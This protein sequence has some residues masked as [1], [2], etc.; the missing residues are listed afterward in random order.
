MKVKAVI[1]Y[2]QPTLSV[3]IKPEAAN[4]ATSQHRGDPEEEKEEKLATR[5]RVFDAFH[6]NRVENVLR[7]WLK[8][9]CGSG[10]KVQKK[11]PETMM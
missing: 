3:I 6:H 10:V 2:P 1:H 11:T 4:W 5:T 9:T 7:A 8:Q